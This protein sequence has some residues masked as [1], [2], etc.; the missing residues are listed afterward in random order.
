MGSAPAGSQTSPSRGKGRGGRSR[1]PGSCARTMGEERTPTDDIKELCLRLNGDIAQH[2]DRMHL[3]LVY[4]QDA[5][6]RRLVTKL[7]VGIGRKTLAYP[8]ATTDEAKGQSF[9][10]ELKAL[11]KDNREKAPIL[12]T[13]TTASS[14]LSKVAKFLRECGNLSRTLEA[15]DTE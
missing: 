4:I 1:C 8:T 13:S 9:Q 6:L 3:P 15:L 12:E 14:V 11:F 7:K 10:D 2:C 5:K